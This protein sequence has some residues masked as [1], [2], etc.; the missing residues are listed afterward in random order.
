MPEELRKRITRTEMDPAPMSKHVYALNQF[1]LP[2]SEGGGTRHTELFSR[3]NGWTH[4][5]VAG[6]RN[7]YTQLEYRSEEPSFQLVRIARAGGNPQSRLASWLGYS[8][9]AFWKVVR[10]DGV[11]L[12]YASTPHPITPLAGWAAAS[13][14]RVPFVLE[15]RDLW[16]ESIVSAGK[17]KPGS[18]LHRLLERVE[19]F[20]V[21]RAA[22]IVCVTKGWEDH[23]A[24]LGGDEVHVVPNGSVFH[25]ETE[26]LLADRLRELRPDV[27]GPFGVFAGAHGAMNG[28]ESIIEAAVDHPSVGFT[29]IGSGPKKAEIQDKAT[30]LGL[31]NIRFV[32]PIPKEEM[33]EV[34]GSFDFGIH[35]IA[36]LDVLDK[37][38]SPNKVFDYLASNLPLVSNAGPGLAR[39]D[40]DGGV[41]VLDT[42]LSA[43]IGELIAAPPEVQEVWQENRRRLMTGPYSRRHSAE[44]LERVLD[45]VSGSGAS[46]RRRSGA[47]RASTRVVHVSSAHGPT[48]NRI[49]RKEARALSDGGYDVHLVTRGP[50]QDIVPSVRHH[51]IENVPAS[52]VARMVLGP[53]KASREVVRIKPDLVHV[54]DPELI[55]LAVLTR[56]LSGAK[57]VFDAHE[58]LP[59]QVMGKHYLPEILRPAVSQ[60]ARLLEKAAGSVL[61]GVVAATPA[62]AR[63]FPAGKT[64]VVKNYPWLEDYETLPVRTDEDS[65]RTGTPFTFGYVG[66]MSRIRGIDQMIEATKGYKLILVGP[67]DE[68]A[69]AAIE[70]AG[71]HVEYAGVVTPDLVPGVI[72]RM[73]AGLVLLE[74]LPNYR[75]S[76]PTKLI[77]YMASGIPF[78]ATDF[79]SWRDL[80]QRDDVGEFVNPSDIS[81]VR[82][83]V[84]ALAENRARAREMGARGRRVFE[85]NLTFDSQVAQLTAF[86]DALL[87]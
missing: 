32:D 75:E 84:V 64:R 78:I 40:A 77:E 68:Y 28:L 10:A 13:L 87:R 35:S 56:L 63:N 86:Y 85:K 81:S 38:M 67:V 8:A 16:P 55:P 30:T 41:G 49:L 72:E 43:A 6:N 76:I 25:E 74:G 83:A 60:F 33:P 62:I 46:A 44:T 47:G 14:R 7:H 4:T 71:E 11:D 2:L 18:L 61:S 50:E 19:A 65:S 1:A 58:D 54:H 39:F 31:K 22:A 45:A 36:R 70:R 37:G 48:D 53:L 80:V 24:R 23:F 9:K 34:L 79:P 69:K 51:T 20:P 3:L 52:R 57:V 66:G 5:I 29:L 12:V 42:D 27:K 59:A 82:E 15:V 21:R 26:P 73:D 17:L